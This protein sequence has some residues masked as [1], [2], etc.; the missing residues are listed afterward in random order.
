[1]DQ[2]CMLAFK[3][4]HVLLCMYIGSHY[5]ALGH[6]FM[7]LRL[8]RL[9]RIIRLARVIEDIPSLRARDVH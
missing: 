1:M 7:M 5:G 4:V 2:G 9:L 6:I 8:A 3:L